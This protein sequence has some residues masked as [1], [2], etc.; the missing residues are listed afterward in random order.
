MAGQAEAVRILGRYALY[1]KLAA[2]GMATVHFGRLMGPVGFARTVAIKR[3]H[4]H[5][6]KDPEFVSMFLDEARLAARIRHPNVVP[7]L[8]VV[9]TEGEL[10]LVMEYVQGESLGAILRAALSTDET[11]PVPFVVSI[12]SQALHGLHAAH[13]AMSERGDPLNIVHRDVSPQNILVGVDG[14]AR[15]LDFGV[16]K[17]AGRLQETRDGQLKGKMAYMAPEQLRG[18]TV[19]R[20]TDVWAMGVVLWESLTGIR[21]FKG[22]NDIEV[23]G[24]ILSAKVAAPSTHNAGVPPAIDEIA[25]KALAPRAADRFASAREMAR[26]LERSVPLVPP[27]DVGDW[28]ARLAANSL[29]AR[30]DV[31]ARIES[32]SE[33]HRPITSRPPPVPDEATATARDASLSAVSD[34]ITQLSGGLSQPRITPPQRPRTMWIALGAAVLGATTIAA[35]TLGMTLGR[36]SS[37]SSSPGGEPAPSAPGATLSPPRLDPVAT[38]PPGAAPSETAPAVASVAPAVSSAAALHPKPAAK[39]KPTSGA[40]GRVLDTRQ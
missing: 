35:L 22:E 33:V 16:A 9:A 15:V 2:G 29:T 36:G 4:E 1:G 8:D 26:A 17:A 19:D 6:A 30:A 32:S 40:L 21:L 12:V 23:F 3:L 37:S 31:V 27:S 5:Y 10:F 13:E 34:P 28:V 11:L 39:P 38:P 18:E 25:L 24:R 20:R 7:T 14:V